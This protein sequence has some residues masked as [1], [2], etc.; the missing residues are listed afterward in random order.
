MFDPPAS[1]GLE[2]KTVRVV[3]YDPAWP[4]LFVAE[5]RRLDGLLTQEGLALELQH[6]GS[7]AIPGLAAKPILDLLAGAPDLTSLARAIDT[8]QHADYIYRGE[9]GIPGRHFFRR[10]NPRQYHIHLTLTGS[11][12]WRDHLLFRNYLRA[13]AEAAAEYATLKQALAERYPFDREAYIEGK[14]EFVRR[15]LREAAT[16]MGDGA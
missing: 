14:T 11:D 6:T 7:T 9:Q 4:R 1:L 10:G 13:H 15:V 8:L 12:F 16:G 5:Q 2:S 3:P